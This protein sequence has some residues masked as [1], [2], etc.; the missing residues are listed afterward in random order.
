MDGARFKGHSLKSLYLKKIKVEKG[1]T[2]EV[3]GR[4]GQFDFCAHSLFNSLKL[5][6]H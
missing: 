5:L 3:K 4:Q 2:E 6:V 1:R